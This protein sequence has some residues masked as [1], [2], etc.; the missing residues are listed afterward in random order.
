MDYRILGTNGLKVSALGVGCMSFA[1]TYGPG[2]A[3][4]Q[5]LS[6]AWFAIRTSDHSR[7]S[8]RR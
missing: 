8:L 1:G 4:S 2:G 5:G 6:H 7:A 3:D